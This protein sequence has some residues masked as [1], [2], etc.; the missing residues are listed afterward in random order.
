MN[1]PNIQSANDIVCALN[2]K[3]DEVNALVNAIDLML[4]EPTLSIHLNH[5]QCLT[6]LA[7]ERFQEAVEL[8]ALADRATL[9]L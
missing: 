8:G 9:R 1:E 7:K 5:I 6:F 2:A 4:C 3:V